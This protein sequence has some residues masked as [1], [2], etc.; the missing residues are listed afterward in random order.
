MQITTGLEDG[1]NGKGF[2]RI[3]VGGGEIEI[4]AYES[5]LTPGLLMIE[6]DS[7]EPSGIP[8]R[9]YHSDGVV[10]E[11]KGKECTDVDE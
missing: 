8:F 6:I 4:I 3:V 11:D 9:V 5:L 2:A 10:Y 1:D 7:D